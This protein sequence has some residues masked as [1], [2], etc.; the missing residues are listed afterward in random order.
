MLRDFPISARIAASDIGRARAWYEEK[1]GFTADA[2]EMGGMAL[3]Y[4]SGS[5]WFLLYQTEAAGTAKNTVGGWEVDDLDATMSDLRSR[6][7][8]FEEYDFGNGMATVEGVMTVE[9]H[10]AAWFRDSE[11]NV[12]ELTDTVSGRSD[13]NR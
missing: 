11:G 10:R 1:L 3:W 9:G 12:F 6:G 4:R 5:T 2:E 13:A 8:A 7:V